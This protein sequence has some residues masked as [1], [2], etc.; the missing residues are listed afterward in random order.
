M[1]YNIMVRVCA[2][3]RLPSSFRLETSVR[4]A[5]RGAVKRMAATAAVRTIFP[6]DSP[7]ESGTE[8]MAACT[9]AFGVYAIMQKS[10]SFFVSLVPARLKNTPAIRKSRAP[11][12]A[13]TTAGPAER[14]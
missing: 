3:H 10:R 5:P 6:Q 7:M 8:P 2:L 12:I 9:V 13:A 11:K 1:L 14:A 4:N